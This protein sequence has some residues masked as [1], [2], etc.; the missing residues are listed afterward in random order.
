M[1]KI[2][3]CLTISVSLFANQIDASNV[4]G[5]YEIAA[6]QINKERTEMKTKENN[7]AAPASTN[8]VNDK[9]VKITGNFMKENQKNISQSGIR[10]KAFQNRKKDLKVDAF[11]HILTS[12]FYE[13]IKELNPRIPQ[14]FSTLINEA[15]VDINTRRKYHNE[16]SDVKEIISMINFNPEDFT[17]DKDKTYEITRKANDELIK[18]V[19]DNSDLFAGSVGMVPMNNVEG[20]VKIINEQVAKNKEMFGIQLFSKALGKSIA[21]DEYLPIFEAASK[22]DI[23]IFLHPVYD[24]SKNDN[25]IVFSW[26]YEQTQAM[27]E[28]VMSDIF[29]KYPNIKILVHHAGAM[30]PFFA[31]RLPLVM[32]KEYVDDFK[33]FYVDT[34]IIGNTKAVDMAIDYFGEDKVIFATDAPVGMQPAGATVEVIESIENLNVSDAV[35]NKIY[36]ENLEKAL[37]TKF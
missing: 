26:E 4:S 18:T 13:D 17:K 33:K 8:P 27:N 9:I 24:M 15:L 37:N 1:K 3:L 20:A 16:Y 14:I 19:K 32:P 7:Q 12:N 2:L 30:V 34:A 22:N 11:T 25:N 5:N 6:N 23:M 29:K 28:I 36:R 31:N 35:K 10:S 21:S